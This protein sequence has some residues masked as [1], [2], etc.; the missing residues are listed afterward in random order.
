[1]A[2]PIRRTAYLR[3]LLDLCHDA[4]AEDLRTLRLEGQSLISNAVEGVHDSAVVAAELALRLALVSLG[5]AL[6]R[7]D[8]A[9]ILTAR[10]DLIRAIRILDVQLA[11]VG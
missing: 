2:A 11:R 7:G 5:N 1:M 8:P 3:R 9:S 10:V 4:S 6:R